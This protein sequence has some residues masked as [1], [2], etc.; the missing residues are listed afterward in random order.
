M[1]GIMKS[2]LKK[3]TDIDKA[4]EGHAQKIILIRILKSM[5]FTE[6][7]IAY[8]MSLSQEKKSSFN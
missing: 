8:N 3:T 7:E 4:T 2:L 1:L 5:G 6:T